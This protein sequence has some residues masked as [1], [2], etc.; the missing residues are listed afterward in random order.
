MNDTSNT[1]VLVDKLRELADNIEAGDIMVYEW[2][3]SLGRHEIEHRIKCYIKPLKP[4][5]L[6]FGELMLG[7]KFKLDDYSSKYMK[8]ESYGSVNAISLDGMF[9]Y[10]TCYIEADRMVIPVEA[11]ED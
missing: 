6:T 1:A 10:H 2:Q 8:V 7:H 11:D 5:N 4:K 9:P 3:E